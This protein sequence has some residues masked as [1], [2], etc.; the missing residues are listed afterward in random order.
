MKAREVHLSY[1]MDSKGNVVAHGP[2]SIFI[3]DD[4]KDIPSTEKYKIIK[5]L[6]PDLNKG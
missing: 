6:N 1:K 2:G 5:Q 3:F 4:L